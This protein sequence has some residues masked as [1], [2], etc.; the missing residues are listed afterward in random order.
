MKMYLADP[1]LVNINTEWHL[2]PDWH[3]RGI[4][5]RAGHR[6]VAISPWRGRWA[7]FSGPIQQPAYVTDIWRYLTSVDAIRNVETWDGWGEPRGWYSHPGS[8]RRRLRDDAG[9]IVEYPRGT[10]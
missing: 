1:D 8:G 7:A 6:W 4:V 3:P 9:H 5:R 2:W 10:P